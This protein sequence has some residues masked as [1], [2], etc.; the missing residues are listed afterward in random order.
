MSS[1]WF[2]GTLV[3]DAPLNEKRVAKGMNS[4]VWNYLQLA[5]GTPNRAVDVTEET[6]TIESEYSQ[7]FSGRPATFWATLTIE[8]QEDNRSARIDFIEP[9][10]ECGR[11]FSGTFTLDDEA[12]VEASPFSEAR[13]TFT[14]HDWEWFGKTLAGIESVDLKENK[15]DITGTGTEDGHQWWEYV[16]IERQPDGTARIEFWEPGG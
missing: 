1:R 11:Y 6:I 3:L 15:I 10:A 7:V 4:H 8:R 5:L 9:G 13:S 14:D 12:T 2:I 16:T